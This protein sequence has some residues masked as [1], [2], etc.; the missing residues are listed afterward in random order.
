MTSIETPSQE[1][2]AQEAVP[3]ASDINPP[4]ASIENPQRS[5]ESVAPEAA[6]RAN[7]EGIAE[8]ASESE[9]DG[10]ADSL[11]WDD[12]AASETENPEPAGN[13][14]MATTE[15]PADTA[16]MEAAREQVAPIQARGGFAAMPAPR[17]PGI[18]KRLGSFVGSFFRRSPR[19]VES[20]RP[21]TPIRKADAPV[22]YRASVSRAEN[23]NAFVGRQVT[24]EN[25]KN[26]KTF[27]DALG[28]VFQTLNAERPQG[29]EKFTDTYKRFS[30]LFNQAI[31]TSGVSESDAI[32]VLRSRFDYEGRV[33]AEKSQRAGNEPLTSP[34]RVIMAK[35]LDEFGV[36]VGPAHQKEREIFEKAKVIR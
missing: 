3:A 21:S 6:D 12:F 4:V 9:Y 2:P 10:N 1:M 36:A 27:Y 18:F 26:A 29:E 33:L 19:T 15:I 32:K 11:T 35:M 13:V 34:A 28:T 20:P 16:A 25:A 31:M 14:G 17:S 5:P 23:S 7:A 8:E 30:K 24:V 22:L